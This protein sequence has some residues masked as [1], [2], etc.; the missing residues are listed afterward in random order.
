MGKPEPMTEAAILP[1]GPEI[2]GAKLLRIIATL[3]GDRV[4][5]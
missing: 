2:V 4:S 1:Y 5:V 3:M